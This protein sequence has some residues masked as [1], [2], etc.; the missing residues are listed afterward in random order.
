VL[1]SAIAAY[2]EALGERE[3]DVPLRALLRA[4]GYHD[5]ELVH[6]VS[7]YGRDFIAKRADPSGAMRQYSIQSK[8]GDLGIGEWRKVR[9]QLEDIRT[10]SIAHPMFDPDLEGAIVLVTNGSLKGDAR[11]AADGYGRSLPA[12]WAF[13]VWTRER[14]IALLKEHLHAAIGDQ[15]RGPL[16][17]FMGSI[18][19]GTVDIKALERHARR[20]IPSSGAV[21]APAQVL[22]AALLADRLATADRLDL[23]CSVA[24]GVLRAQ[25]VAASD[26]EPLDADTAADIQAAGEFFALYA[27]AL[28]ARCVPELLEPRA[29]LEAHHEF[30][31][32]ATYPVRC[33]RL[34]E[35]LAL[36]ALW[37]LRR[38]QDADDIV[39]WLASFIERQPGAAHP[40]SDRQAVSLLAPAVL[41]GDRRGLLTAWLR[42]TIKWT[43]DRYEGTGLGLAGTDAGPDMEIDYLLGDLEHIDRPARR[44][45]FVAGTV[46]DL[47]S[48]L[49]LDELYDD[50]RNEFQAVRIVPDIRH[51]PVGREAW[52]RDG[53]GL[54]QELN[55]PY[56][57]TYAADDGWQ[58]A[59]H[60]RRAVTWPV[61][62]GLEW[63]ALAVWG[64]LRD[65]FSADVLRALAQAGG[66]TPSNR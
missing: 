59:P 43:A 18:D 16:L 6:G 42:G 7:E 41:L 39:E 11:G 17:S 40:I 37:R 26:Q 30:G 63:E 33:L 53:A 51:P 44:E 47:A 55:P 66:P 58:T 29:L 48:L 35:N 21:V 28:W 2:V 15:A 5:I 36:L 61:R 60:H 22:E 19:E 56:A 23:A 52:I 24:I 34:A 49:E 20:W 50:A 4:E 45:S 65:R 13:E 64:M 25:L 8:A 14:L 54:Q 27:E 9:E 46:L 57:D 1:E 12:P 38:G 10:V 31:F 62:A 3:L 32:W